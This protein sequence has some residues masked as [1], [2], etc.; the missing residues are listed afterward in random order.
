MTRRRR[1][2]RIIN[3]MNVVPYI[4]VMLV[5]LIIFMIASPMLDRSQGIKIELP[6]TKSESVPEI[7][8][9]LPI[10][11]KITENAEFLLSDDIAQDQ[12]MTLAQLAPR[13]LAIAKKQTQRPIV[14]A[15]DKQVAYGEVAK[16]MGYFKGQGINI[17]L[18]T[19]TPSSQNNN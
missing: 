5:L 12:K 18:M 9:K 17:H 1:P 16:L 3:Q 14:I 4:D 7:A 8:N 2:R 15:G 19:Q 11:I 10:L 13:V 6:E